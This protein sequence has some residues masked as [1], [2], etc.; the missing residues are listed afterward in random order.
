VKKSQNVI[1]SVYFLGNNQQFHNLTLPNYQSFSQNQIARLFAIADK[2]V[3]R[4]F[5]LKFNPK[6]FQI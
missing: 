1:V 3:I 5:N 2:L 6:Q 4:K